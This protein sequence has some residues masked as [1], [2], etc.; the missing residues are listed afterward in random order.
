MFTCSV[1]ISYKSWMTNTMSRTMIYLMMTSLDQ[2]IEAINKFGEVS[3]RVATDSFFLCITSF[4]NGIMVNGGTTM[5]HLCCG[6]DSQFTAVYFM[7]NESN[8]A[9]TLENFI[10]FYDDTK[11]LVMDIDNILIGRAV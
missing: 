10:W 6:H 8:M 11:A 3:E 1:Y 9:G 5:L 4:D 7:N 2:A